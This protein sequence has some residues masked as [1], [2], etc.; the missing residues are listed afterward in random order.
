MM[1]VLERNLT[2]CVCVSWG[3]I[4]TNSACDAGGPVDCRWE[5]ERLQEM[6]RY[7]S[8][9]LELTFRCAPHKPDIRPCA[10]DVQKCFVESNHQRQNGHVGDEG[11]PQGVLGLG[12]PRG[13]VGSALRMGR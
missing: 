8:Q 11:C 9:Y 10:A 2:V 4:C 3:G 12:L 5:D 6:V 1:G 13:L 7:E